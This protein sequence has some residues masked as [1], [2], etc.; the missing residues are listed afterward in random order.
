MMDDGSVPEWVPYEHHGCDPVL[1]P[2][3][4][5]SESCSGSEEELEPMEVDHD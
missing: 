2:V 1:S 4:E 5:F 3:E